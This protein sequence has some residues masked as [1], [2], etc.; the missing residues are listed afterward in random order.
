LPALD[1]VNVTVPSSL[2]ASPNPVQVQVCIPGSTGQQVCS[3][4]VPLYIQ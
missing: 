3:N 4:Q 2:P 1:Q